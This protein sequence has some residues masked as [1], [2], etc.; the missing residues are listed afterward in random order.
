MDLALN[1]L[2]RLICHKTQQTKPNQKLHC[3]DKSINRC[4][5]SKLDNV[6]SSLFSKQRKY[7]KSKAYN[8]E[9]PFLEP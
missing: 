4:K 8:G 2:Q 7:L 1:N 3:S 9:S 5:N 6:H